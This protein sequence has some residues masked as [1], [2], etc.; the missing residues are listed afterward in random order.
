MQFLLN[1]IKTVS[2]IGLMFMMTN[3]K[4]QCAETRNFV[5][6]LDVNQDEKPNSQSYA[7][8]Q[9]LLIALLQKQPIIVTPSL[10]NNFIS[11]KLRFAQSVSEQKILDALKAKPI[12][13]M[14]TILD[15]RCYA[16]EFKPA[17]WIVKK[18]ESIAYILIPTTYFNQK[19]SFNI[20]FPMKDA[21][22]DN[23]TIFNCY[24]KNNTILGNLTKDELLLGVK[25][26]HCQEVGD[27]FGPV[28]GIENQKQAIEKFDWTELFVT[29]KDLGLLAPTPAGTK[30]NLP[31]L[32][33]AQSKKRWEDMTQ[34]EKEQRIELSPQEKKVIQD[35]SQYQK[36]LLETYKKMFNDDNIDENVFE[37][38]LYSWFIFLMGH[39]GNLILGDT[40]ASLTAKQFL[41]FISFLN[42][43]IKTDLLFYATCY[44]GGQHTDPTFQYAYEHT[45]NIIK[46][47]P[48]NLN[49]TIASGA[50]LS[51]K[52]Y[53][54]IF[55]L[56]LPVTKLAANPLDRITVNNVLM[57]V[58]TDAD[59]N[60]FFNEL[61][62]Y[63][64]NAQNKKT[65]P[66]IINSIHHFKPYSLRYDIYS[67]SNI[68]LI[69]LP[70]T[71]WFKAIDQKN[72]FIYFK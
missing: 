18:I 54:S 61:E 47:V 8:L 58:S 24:G 21:K 7:V 28:S 69:R 70:N 35:Y 60:I 36:G 16:I 20:K 43:S 38:Y 1:M 44:G 11:R 51:E 27:P 63:F 72:L 64:M 68:P 34:A 32:T 25:I 5:I 9:K 71:E 22:D 45:K 23:A 33:P 67:I 57:A 65:I 42:Y 46:K 31:P 3:Q 13:D 39:G 6:L 55:N 19:K 4:T 2:F 17:D 15:L 56:A 37:K 30:K 29:R 49:Y 52:S 41:K 48:F 14:Q 10:W 40:L 50:L 59:F 26:D 53:G 66:D 62:K 12:S